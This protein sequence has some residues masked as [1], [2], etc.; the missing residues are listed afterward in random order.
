MVIVLSE[1]VELET[2]KLAIGKGVIRVPKSPAV[3]EVL[4]TPGKMVRPVEIVV[5][6]GTGRPG[7]RVS[8][9]V[10]TA[11]PADDDVV[12]KIT[13][14][15]SDEELE[16]GTLETDSP[17]ADEL[18]EK[19]EK[20]GVVKAAER[21]VLMG[22]VR[23]IASSD[24]MVDEEAEVEVV[25][26]VFAVEARLDVSSGSTIDEEVVEMDVVFSVEV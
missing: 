24:S 15:V 10:L 20:P 13:M 11:W 26:S 8:V 2:G 4:G 3:V 16:S 5:I 23:L 6:V 25:L 21:D 14:G 22:E 18:L 1:E 17:I 19:K 9:K 7:M 12:V